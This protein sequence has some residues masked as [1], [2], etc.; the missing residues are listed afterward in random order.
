LLWI[1]D[2]NA[3]PQDRS[4]NLANLLTYLSGKSG[5]VSSTIVLAILNQLA[6]ALSSTPYTLTS[7]IAKN[8]FLVT[9]GASAF[10]FNLATAVSMIGFGQITIIKVDSGAGVIQVAPNGADVID[11]AGNVSCYLGA[12]WQ[13]LT[14]EA[15]ASGQWAVL[16]GTFA[17][18][19]S[20]DTNGSQLELGKL[21]HL[22]LGNATDRQV[23]GGILTPTA[24][25]TWYASALTAWG[26]GGCPAGAKGIRAKVSFSTTVAAGGKFRMAVDFSDNNSSAPLTYSTAHPSAIDK[27]YAAAGGQEYSI[28]YEV[29]IPL[30]NSGQFY[31]FTETAINIT[32]A[33]T[34]VHVAI[35]GFYLG[36]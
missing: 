12:Q 26:V 2:P 9:T 32:L 34:A 27:G 1:S 28:T 31:M 16:G 29:D 21:H 20:V 22:P 19:Q 25:G 18:A 24:A 15:T 7:S 4:F 11:K 5:L 14:L 8:T 3:T 6:I 35:V 23:G 33:T 36:D 17:P 13:S 10:V 30:N